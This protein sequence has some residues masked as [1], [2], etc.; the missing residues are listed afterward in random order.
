MSRMNSIN[1]LAAAMVSFTFL[2]SPSDGR[3]LYDNRD[4]GKFSGSQ[5]LA[6]P[7]FCIAAHRIGNIV[8]AVSNNATLGMQY[9]ST[10][11]ID[12]FINRGIPK[13]CEVPK[14]SGVDYLYGASFWIGAIVNRDTLV[15]VGFDGWQSNQEFN[16]DPPP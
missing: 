12:C 13:S 8:L 9:N 16:P 4:K 15:T 11:D 5:R 1:V 7:A 2:Y 3:A 10:A 6:A 14:N